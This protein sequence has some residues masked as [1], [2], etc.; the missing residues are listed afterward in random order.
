MA[1]GLFTAFLRAV[2]PDGFPKAVVR[3][4]LGIAVLAS[5]ACALGDDVTARLVLGWYEKYTLVVAPVILGL[6][7]R[8]FVRGPDRVL[9]GLIAIGT[10][11]QVACAVNDILNNTNVIKTFSAEDYGIF[12]FI[13]FQAL[14]LAVSN[15]R[16][17]QHAELL[18]HELDDKNVTLRRMDRV[19]DEFLAN[20][21][22]ELRTPLHGMIGLAESLFD[23]ATGPLPEATR[24]DLRMIIASGR[25]LST[26][27]NDTLDFSKL[28]NDKMALA[29]KPVDPRAMVD[30]VL[31]LSTPLVGTKTVVL[32]NCID[33]NVRAVQA[34]EERLE[35]VLHN[36]VGNAIKFTEN[37]A[38]EVSAHV[39]GE[40][41]A[42]TVTDSGIGI[43]PDHQ[44]RIFEA[45]EQ[46][47]GGAAR[48]YGGTGLGLTI[49]KKLVELH[50][51]ALTLTSTEGK[52]SA[53]TFTLPLA[54]E[55]PAA[56]SR[57]L[58]TVEP[59]A[60]LDGSAPSK[61]AAASASSLTTSAASTRARSEVPAP[62]DGT[63]L[64]TSDAHKS[65]DTRPPIMLSSTT[66]RAS[67]DD[68]TDPGRAI[69]TVPRKRFRILAV[70]DDPVNLA[71]LAHHLG[72]GRYDVTQTDNGA[73]ALK[74]VA[75]QHF[76]CIVLDV[77]MP[78]MTGYEV[79][80]EIRKEYPA[81]QL[82]ILLLTAK[83]QELDLVQ[84]F[85]SGANDYLI[86]PF[87]KKELLSRINTHVTLAQKNVAYGRF[88]PH[89]FLRLLGKD[90][91]VDV[92]IG[93]QVQKDLTVLFCDIR[94]FTALSEGMS[95]AQTFRFLNQLF[96]R[97]APVV[98]ECGG[99]IDK[100]IGDAVMAL[101]PG[102]PRDALNAAMRIVEEVAAYN[103]AHVIEND[104]T[105]VSVGIGV[106]SGI[107]ML[108]TVGEAERMEGTVISDTVNL[109]SRIEGITRPLGTNVLA[110]DDAL[111]DLAGPYLA[112][113][114]LGQVRV[115][116]RKGHIGVW[117]LGRDD[118][119][120][121]AHALA[122]WT[123]GDLAHATTAFEALHESQPH[124]G[125]VAFYLR[126]CRARAHNPGTTWDPTVDFDAK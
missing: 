10:S 2:F 3:A 55:A 88:V 29:T 70:D 8:V 64:P 50:G 28:R 74:L 53:F 96:E 17:R 6:L 118:D 22:H 4:A 36:L 58:T 56:L 46:V 23:G 61:S 68:V 62:A 43:S 103:A 33:T 81:H 104:G 37:G 66:A 9:S 72:R 47:D 19:K 112:R 75:T 38:V 121:F 13:F 44:A 91:V 5:I 51:G 31:A 114:A 41:L 11:V 40:Q 78:R 111:K 77:M 87:G 60:P 99:F 82:P 14:V 123:E 83:N 98:R 76:D 42:I 84:G 52:G 71:I 63:S 26:L 12:G 57:S 16:A 25:R 120:S 89:E 73:D 24:R 1:V 100:Y 59:A 116:G 122:L 119:G 48:A 18:A 94:G 45:F 39:V 105:P 20:T 85:D 107:T 86:K 117:E 115:K 90:D 7:V 108:G 21:S 95:G 109:A 79:C 67:F 102:S 32:K 27:V 106:H 15:N 97:I 80:R 69:E 93:D 49:C 101:F 54:A 30:V 34:D 110:S 126:Q 35:Q 65:S 92:E 113:R 125:P 124:D